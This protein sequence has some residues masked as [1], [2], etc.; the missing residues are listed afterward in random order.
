MGWPILHAEGLRRL[1]LAVDRRAQNPNYEIDPRL[2][3]TM[4]AIF[5]RDVRPNRTIRVTKQ[6]KLDFIARY[7][8]RKLLQAILKLDETIIYPHALSQLFACNVDIEF[9]FFKTEV[10]ACRNSNYCDECNPELNKDLGFHYGNLCQYFEQKTAP[11]RNRMKNCLPGNLQEA[12]D[13]LELCYI[14]LLKNPHNI[15]NFYYEF[16]HFA[17]CAAYGITSERTDHLIE[18]LKN[19]LNDIETVDEEEEEDEDDLDEPIEG[20]RSDLTNQ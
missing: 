13:I 6:H 10:H 7:K 5:T 1:R 12:V 20:T 4:H 15:A 2:T 16:E 18:H 17:L 11:K 19:L 9:G 3:N 14:E 8:K